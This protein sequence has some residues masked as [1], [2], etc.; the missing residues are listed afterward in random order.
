MSLSFDLVLCF[1]EGGRGGGGGSRNP[2]ASLD[3]SSCGSMEVSDAKA[4]TGVK[5]Q[6]GTRIADFAVRMSMQ[7]ADRG[8]RYGSLY[9]VIITWEVGWRGTAKERET[10]HVIAVQALALIESRV[11]I[12]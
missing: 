6:A 7:T 9:P 8:H 2:L 4:P 10:K 5:D 1:L 11:M 3:W 12:T